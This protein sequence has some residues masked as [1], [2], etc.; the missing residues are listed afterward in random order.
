MLWICILIFL[1]PSACLGGILITAII[2]DKIRDTR[3]REQEVSRA[4]ARG[5][6]QC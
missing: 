2:T 4:L 3:R 5:K 6:I 1:L